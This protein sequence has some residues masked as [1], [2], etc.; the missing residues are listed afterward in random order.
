M[1]AIRSAPL[2]RPMLLAAV[3]AVLAG[4]PGAAAD[5]T[6]LRVVSSTTMLADI[7]RQVG[8][9][10]VES[11]SL[12][13]PG[14]DG[15]TFEPA[16]DDIKLIGSARLVVVNGLG[17]EGWLDQ[18]IAASGTKAPV[19]VAS[20]G[21]APLAGGADE[22]G[23]QGRHEH[24]LDPHAWQDA[25]NG[26][27]YAQN[28]R[29]ALSAADPAGKDDYAAWTDAYVAQ[30]RVVDAWVRKQIAALP[31]ESRVLV[32]SHDALSYYGKAYGLEIEPV[33]GIATGQEPDA[34]HIAALIALLGRRHV[35]AVFIENV[36][37]PKV[38][39]Q[40]GREGGA[41]LGGSLFSDSLD[42]PGRQA[43]TYLGMFLANTR[44][45]VRGLR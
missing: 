21:V 15:H 2:S 14:V 45:I 39:E 1:P 7:V 30:L 12:L 29:D 3:L 16:P 8:G 37:S 18:A 33:E 43:G 23:H 25:R 24:G 40:I 22:P 27:V 42:Q 20:A 10:R 9:D 11:L 19:T 5:A 4:V 36:S 38:V 41:Q 17:F 32:T 26:I 44:V 28:I 13:K 35:K 31:A 6:P 34:A